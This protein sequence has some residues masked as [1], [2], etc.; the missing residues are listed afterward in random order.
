MLI[1]GTCSGAPVRAAREWL[2]RLGNMS[3]PLPVPAWLLASA[4]GPVRAGGRYDGSVIPEGRP[5]RTGAISTKFT[6]GCPAK[7]FL[8]RPATRVGVF[9]FT[10]II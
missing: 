5:S 2:N 8:R 9:N 7:N 10:V 6:Q 4:V 1:P 3:V